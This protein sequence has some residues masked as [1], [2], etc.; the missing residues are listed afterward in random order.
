MIGDF[1]PAVGPFP[2]IIYN[3]M[4]GATSTWR[5]NSLKTGLLEWEK[6]ANSTSNGSSTA[7]QLEAN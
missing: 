4:S 5:R 7:A 2:E 1:R 6:P 3:E